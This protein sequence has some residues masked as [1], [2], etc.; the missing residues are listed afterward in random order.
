MEIQGANPP[1]GMRLLKRERE[2]SGE[3]VARETGIGGEGE[4]RELGGG[5]ESTVESEYEGI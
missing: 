1:G 2:G 3:R 5:R 4:R